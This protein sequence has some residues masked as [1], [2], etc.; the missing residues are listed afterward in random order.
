MITVVLISILCVMSWSQVHDIPTIAAWIVCSNLLWAIELSF[1]DQFPQYRREQIVIRSIQH[2]IARDHIDSDFP[3]TLRMVKTRIRDLWSTVHAF[4]RPISLWTEAEDGLQPVLPHAVGAAILGWEENSRAQRTRKAMW[5]V[6]NDGEDSTAFAENVGRLL[7]GSHIGSGVSLVDVSKTHSI[8][9]P[10]IYGVVT[11]SPAYRQEYA[12]NTPKAFTDSYKDLPLSGIYTDSAEIVQS[13]ISEPLV[14]IQ[15]LHHTPM[16]SMPKVMVVVHGVSTT[17]H[18]TELMAAIRDVDRYLPGIMKFLDIVIV[19]H[20]S[21]FESTAQN[22]PKIMQNI[23][24]LHILEPRTNPCMF[25]YSADTMDPSKLCENLFSLL[26]D[27]MYRTG[28][29]QAKTI[30]TKLLP[31]VPSPGTTAAD[32]STEGVFC[33]LYAVATHRDQLLSCLAGLTVI[34]QA[35]IDEKIREDNLKIAEVL[36]TLFTSTSIKRDLARVPPEHSLAVLNLTHQVIDRGLPRHVAADWKA[37]T[38]RAHRFLGSL[39]VTLRLLPDD[40]SIAGVVLSG[41]HPIAHGG[42]SDIYHGKYSDPHG[43]TVEVALKVLRFFQ[44][45]GGAALET[46]RKKFCKEALVWRYLDHPNIVQFLGVDTTTFPDPAMAI[47]TRWMPYGNV[48]SYISRNSPCSPYAIQLL[49]DCIAGLEYLHSSDIVHGDLRGANVLVDEDGH[50]RLTDFGLAIFIDSETSGKSSTRGG[51]TRW[52]APEL[53]VPLPGQSSRTTRASDMWAFGCL[54][55]EVSH[56]FNLYS[57]GPFNSTLFQ[58][59]D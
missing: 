59:L 7:S 49:R 28:G 32:P 51:T 48:I 20:S 21:F 14:R 8:F 40:I 2:H 26:L 36:D 16:E 45:H 10:F 9:W 53:L 4:V 22:F 38:L 27:G 12:I 13:L 50:A 5:C 56:K 33:A 34:K 19:S 37:F 11:A 42:F 17:V 1:G 31:L 54:C 57:R 25:I 39:A 35:Q 29:D 44:E 23:C 6:V 52:M 41:P 30:M 46:R 43:N 3:N 47:V 15:R 58:G 18:A 24:V 55:C